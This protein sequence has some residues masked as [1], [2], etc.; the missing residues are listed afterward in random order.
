MSWKSYKQI[1]L[2]RFTIDFELVTLD[3]TLWAE[4]LR[5]HLIDLSINIYPLISIW[6]Y[7]DSK[8][9]IAKVKR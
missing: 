4:W 2:T 9:A 7:Y 3:N 8:T 6:L 5:N 1:F